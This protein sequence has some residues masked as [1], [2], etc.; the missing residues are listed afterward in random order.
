MAAAAAQLYKRSASSR[1]A[2]L[3]QE[4]RRTNSSTCAATAAMEISD[5]LVLTT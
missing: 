1:A 4:P 5:G 2:R 3:I